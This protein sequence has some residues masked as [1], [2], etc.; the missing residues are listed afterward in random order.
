MPITTIIHKIIP[1]RAH[2]YN[3]KVYIIV[4]C[5]SFIFAIIADKSISS[6]TIVMFA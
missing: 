5:I 3:T 6:F 2:N 1:Y 4:Y